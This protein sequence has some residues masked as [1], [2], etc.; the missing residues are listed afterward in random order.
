MVLAERLSTQSIQTKE[1]EVKGKLLHQSLNAFAM[2]LNIALRASVMLYCR[3]AINIININPL[4]ASRLT[5]LH[6]FMD[7]KDLTIQ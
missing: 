3:T 6:A 5:D 2:P 7:L 1:F 4:L